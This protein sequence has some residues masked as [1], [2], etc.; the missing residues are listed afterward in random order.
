MGSGEVD[1]GSIG[2]LTERVSPRVVSGIASP[3]P[4]PE[5]FE[6][7]SS[8][9]SAAGRKPM[10]SREIRRIFFIE[11]LRLVGVVWPI[12]SGVLIFNECYALGTL[13]ILTKAAAFFSQWVG[14][15]LLIG[16]I[17]GWRIDD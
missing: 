16:Y 6:L 2:G 8:D 5:R 13:D 15:G 10:R 4:I 7:P 3:A 11:L 12:L 1:S 17:E 9:G 14:P